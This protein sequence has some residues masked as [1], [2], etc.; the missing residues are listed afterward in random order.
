MG[1][2]I[3]QKEYLDVLDEQGNKTGIVKS[4]GEIHKNN[5][6]HREVAV[7]I[8]NLEGEIL[9]QKRSMDKKDAPGVWA[10]CAG[11]VGLNETPLETLYKE[12]KEEVGIDIDIKKLTYMFTLRNN[13]EGNRH[14]I[15]IFK[16]IT[17]DKINE[18][19]IQTEELTALRFFN[20]EE[21]KKGALNNDPNLFLKNDEPTRCI[22]A[23]IDEKGIY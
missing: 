22:F 9:L 23:W 3:K 5:L 6:W 11:H 4:R 16:Y 21:V 14:F 8:F 10:L 18:F 7:L 17:E 15:D 19:K 20:Y 12:V 13:E 1:S 2:E